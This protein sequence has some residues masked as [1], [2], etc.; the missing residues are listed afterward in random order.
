MAPAA[1]SPDIT[2][3]S[4]PLD[5]PSLYLDRE[6]SLLAFQRRVLGEARDVRNPLLERVKFLSI[7]FSNIDEFFM[8]R[9][10]LLNQR[11]DSSKN[12][13]RATEHLERMGNELRT[14]LSDA[15]A[16]WVELDLALSQAGIDIREY[17]NLT[18]TERDALDTYFHDVV[19]PVLTP[20]AFDPG[21]PFPHITSVRL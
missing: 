5:H 1:L 15:Y 20:L 13:L 21:H 6:M 17:R 7:L 12:D 18:E 9:V 10:A 4:L 14:L 3:A 2:T 8:V 19:H 11:V 16:V